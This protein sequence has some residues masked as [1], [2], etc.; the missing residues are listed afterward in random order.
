MRGLTCLLWKWETKS[1]GS[2]NGNILAIV[3][4]LSSIILLLIGYVFGLKRL[5]LEGSGLKENIENPILNNKTTE[6][7]EE[8]NDP[9]VTVNK[10]S[11]LLPQG[12]KTVS[13]STGTIEMGYDPNINF[14]N[15]DPKSGSRIS[16]M[17]KD[18]GSF[19]Y[20]LNLEDYDGGSRHKFIL[21][22][23]TYDYKSSNYREESLVYN[24]WSCLVLYGISVSQWPSTEGM[25]AVSGN[26]AIAFGTWLDSTK[27]VEQVIRTIKLL[28]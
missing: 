12:W 27:D 14:P 18:Q 11:Y 7:K 8:A 5:D 20:Y 6:V 26:K 9:P 13:D 1:V 28:K 16:I 24:G 17:P 19:R 10:L 4:I 15:T 21:R 22:G 3:L 25:C 2:K 23:V